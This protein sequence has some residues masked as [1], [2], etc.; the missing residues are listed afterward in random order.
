MNTDEILKKYRK[1]AVVGISP[2]EDR[3]SHYVTEYMMEQGYEVAGVNPGQTEVLG[4]PCYKSLKDVPGPLEIVNV[5]RSSEH[6][7]GLVKELIPLRPK[8]LWLQVGIRDEAAEQAAR[9]AGIEV[10][11]G[12]C[13]MVEHRQLH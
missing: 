3:P 9:D 7:A 1:L 11:A 13:I 5:F 10:V 4:R 12:K 6:V 8:V 2:N